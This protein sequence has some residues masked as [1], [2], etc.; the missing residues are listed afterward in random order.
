MRGSFEMDISSTMRCWTFGQCNYVI[1]PV[2][3]TAPGAHSTIYSLTYSPG[4]LIGYSGLECHFFVQEVGGLS[5]LLHRPT[6][7]II[8]WPLNNVFLSI[9]PAYL[10]DTLPS[11]SRRL[12]ARQPTS[13]QRCITDSTRGNWSRNYS[14]TLKGNTQHQFP[15]SREKIWG[16]FNYTQFS[17]LTFSFSLFSTISSNGQTISGAMLAFFRN[18]FPMAY[19]HHLY[20]DSGEKSSPAASMDFHEDYKRCLINSYD[21]LYPFGDI[22]RFLART[23][24]RSLTASNMFVEALERGAEVLSTV[25]TLDEVSFEAKCSSHLLKMNYCQECNGAPKVKSCRGY[26]LNV[27]RGCL[28]QHVGSLDRPWTTYAQSLESLV[29]IVR[30]KDGYESVLRGLD[31]RLSEAV[32]HFMQHGAELEPKVSQNSLMVKYI[33]CVNCLEKRSKVWVR[34]KCTLLNCI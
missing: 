16:S 27:M 33:L 11:Y 8:N 24:D 5:D 21:K 7:N 26:C 12:R 14:T 20:S 10:Q 6:E 15:H 13:L 31:G 18:L 34:S 32:L 4:D 25:E 28:T 22:P 3:T 1:T 9:S 23:V 17:V 30:S 29:H 2:T 19:H